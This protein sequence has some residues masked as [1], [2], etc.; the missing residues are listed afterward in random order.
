MAHN[1]KSE[2]TQRHKPS[3]T[4]VGRNNKQDR[5]SRTSACSFSEQILLE[6]CPKCWEYAGNKTD[7]SH[8]PHGIWLVGESDNKQENKT[9]LD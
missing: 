2:T 7:K 4:R 8:S 3:Q 9:V 1:Q 6:H 5:A